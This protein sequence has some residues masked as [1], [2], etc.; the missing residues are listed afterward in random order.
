MAH[1][2]VLEQ[3]Q[4]IPRPLAE[5]FPFFADAANLERIT[6]PEL[7]FQILTPQPIA[8]KPGAVIDYKLRLYG[9]PFRWR[10]VIEEFVPGVRFVD[11]QARGPYKLWRHTHE[12]R[13]EGGV[14]V[15]RDRV[16]YELPFGPLGRVAHRLAVRAQLAGIFAHR[17]AFVERTFPGAARAA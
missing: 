15:M 14:T 2:Y 7:G 13:E 8:M 3:E 12:F 5:V 17:H 6:P 16:E 9:I 11:T 4:R 1:R 10:T